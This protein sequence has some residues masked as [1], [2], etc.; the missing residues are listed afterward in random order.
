M[1]GI[2]FAQAQG[3]GGAGGSLMT[4]VPIIL[5]IAVFYFLLIRP[6]QKREKE[7][8]Q[9]IASLEKGDRVITVGG[10]HATVDAIKDEN[11]VVLKLTGNTKVDFSKSSIQSKL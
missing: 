9:M 4:F 10:I 1:T 2:A 8:K 3:G 11:T 7:R 5:M 6:Q